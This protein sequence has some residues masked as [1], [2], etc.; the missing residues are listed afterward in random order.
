MM[1]KTRTGSLVLLGTGVYGLILS[2]R[3]PLGKWHEPG[4][5]AF[6]LIVSFLLALSGLFIFLSAREKVQIDWREL[7]KHQ[8]TPFRI[9][10]L[11][12]GFILALDRLGYLVTSTLYVFALLFWVSRYRV[13]VAL[14]LA[15]LIGI[16]SWYVFGRLFAT[17]LP[18]GILGF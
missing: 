16:G 2:L 17:P 8:W 6:P 18:E 11:T 3:L 1:N 12:A 5:G 7:A 15:L 4:A 10:I 13:W 14:S 9:V